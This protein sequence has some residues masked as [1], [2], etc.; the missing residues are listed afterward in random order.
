MIALLTLCLLLGAPAATARSEAE[1]FEHWHEKAEAGDAEGQFNVAY[2]YATGKGVERDEAEAVRWYRLAAEQGYARAQHNLAV[3]YQNG[4]GVETDPERAYALFR[5]AAD[6]GFEPSRKQVLPARVA[7]AYAYHTGKG[8]EQNHA[9]A[10]EHYREP[11]EA[12]HATAQY[13]L[14]ILYKDG[15]GVERDLATARRLLE[16]AAA[17]DHDRAKEVLAKLP[18]PPAGAGPRVAFRTLEERVEGE[19][20]RRRGMA[21]RDGD[22]VLQDDAKA[23]EWL[24][25]GAELGDTE[26]QAGLA[27]LLDAGRGTPRDQAAAAE[28]FRRAAEQGHT[29]A[30]FSLGAMLVHGEGV[31]QDVT[32]GLMWLHLSREESHSSRY[33][34]F[35]LEGELDEATLAEGRRRAEEW[36]AGRDGADP[37]PTPL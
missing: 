12:G 3:V 26:A 20:A 23:V 25:K 24:R 8:V 22:G 7:L 4:N 16:L 1:V 10:A 14:G 5:E 36:R 9:R 18:P 34:I 28:W 15:R 32:E 19:R 29:L 33:L 30:Q 31:P 17:Q 6:A 27:A 11:A 13:N 21:Y 35:R 37:L 2:R